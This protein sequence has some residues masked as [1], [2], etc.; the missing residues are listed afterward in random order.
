MIT[1]YGLSGGVISAVVA[2]KAHPSALFLTLVLP[3]LY[4]AHLHWTKF[5]AKS[6]RPPSQR[7]LSCQKDIGWYRRLSN[8]RFC[9]EKHES[10]WLEELEELAI[11]RLQMARNAVPEFNMP[12]KPAVHEESYL[13]GGDLELVLVNR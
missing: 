6:E 1:V 7:C 11:R 10:E 12:R 3:I 13:S 2:A 4:L 5:Q 9:C 8:H